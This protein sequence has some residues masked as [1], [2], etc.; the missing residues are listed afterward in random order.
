MIAFL[1][2]AKCWYLF[3]LCFVQR[4]FGLLLLF[5]L[6]KDEATRLK[7]P[8]AFSKNCCTK[9]L[10]CLYFVFVAVKFFVFAFV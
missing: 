2:Y 9:K 4:M 1:E 10:F 8:A 3:A 7:L 5:A 6:Q